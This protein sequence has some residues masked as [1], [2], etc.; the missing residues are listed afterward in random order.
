[1][2]MEDPSKY[3]TDLTVAIN[4]LTSAQESWA[5]SFGQLGAASNNW[6]TIFA[7]VTSGSGLWKLQN[8]V[9]AISNV[10]EAFTKSSDENRKAIMDSLEANLGLA[11]SYDELIKQRK[12]I[13]DT[14]L[15]AMF[16]EDLG[17]AREAEKHTKK[18]YDNLIKSIEK[19]KKK[20]AKKFKKSLL[21]SFSERYDKM[22]KSTKPQKIQDFVVGESLSPF[23]KI[24]TFFRGEKTQKKWANQWGSGVKEGRTESGASKMFKK[25]KNMKILPNLGK[26]LTMTLAALGKFLMYGLLIVLGITVLAAIIKK[27]WPMFSDFFKS[28]GKNFI[29]VGQAIK[30]ILLGVFNLFKAI[31][32]GKPKKALK[33]FF[34]QIFLNVVKLVGNLLIGIFKVLVGVVVGIL[35]GIWNWII[36]KL[37]GSRFNR[38]KYVGYSNR[39]NKDTWHGLYTGGEVSKTGLFNVGER[40]KETVMLPKGTRV[41]NTE[42]SRNMGGNTI[43]VHVNGRVGASDAEIRDIANKVAREINLRMNRTG[44]TRIGA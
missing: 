8:R 42:Q 23:K 20:R 43:H 5:R 24:D 1:M 18:F 38:Y 16:K 40:G 36:D 25:I 9:R 17:S 21:P 6:W 32:D 35:A 37:P 3:T 7:R 13:T 27:G 26:F 11:N 2:T 44:A 34:N 10:F 22:M 4:R 39:G 12:K 41:F 31:F 14:P 28:A 15:F 29:K 30:G 19:E 33:I